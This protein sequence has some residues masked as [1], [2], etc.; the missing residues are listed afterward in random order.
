MVAYMAIRYSHTNIVAQDPDRL[1]AFYTEVFDCVRSGPV[2]DLAGEWL[3]R[4][5]GLRGASVHGV[6]LRL[7]GHGE[8]GPTLELFRLGDLAAAVPSVVNRPGLMHIAFSVDDIRATLDRLVA[9]GGEALGEIAEA[10]VAGVG[11]AEFVY[12]RDPEGNIVELQS[13]KSGGPLARRD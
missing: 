11:R 2:R 5:T 13:W 7:P 1:E 6:H 10:V 4:G 8:D 9:S 3:E 12:T